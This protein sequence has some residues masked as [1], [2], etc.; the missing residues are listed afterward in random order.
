MVAKG[1]QSTFAISLLPN[2]TDWNWI[3]GHPNLTDDE[4]GSQLM[5]G[6]YNATQFLNAD[7]PTELVATATNPNNW[8][9]ALSQFAFGYTNTSANGSQTL[10]YTNLT[11]EYYN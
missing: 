4:I 1:V 5:I 2:E 7:Y 3:P 9:F 6:E 8:T 11:V 10:N